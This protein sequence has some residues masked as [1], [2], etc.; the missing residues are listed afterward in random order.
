MTRYEKK[1]YEIVLNSTVHPTAEQVYRQLKD[2]CPNVVLATVYNNLNR[3]CDEGLVRRI[4]I[5]GSPDRYDRPVRHDHLVC[6]RCGRLVDIDLGDMTASLRERLG[7][8]FERYDLKVFYLCP[9]CRQEQQ[10]G[11]EGR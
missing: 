5:E 7:E 10:E 4:S 6:R 9:A 1:I 2:D 3:L 8:D 11:E